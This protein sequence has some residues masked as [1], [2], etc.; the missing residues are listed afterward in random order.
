MDLLS[1]LRASPLICS[2]SWPDLR[3]CRVE[4]RSSQV[5]DSHAMKITDWLDVVASISRPA[6]RAGCGLKMRATNQWALLPFGTLRSNQDD[7]LRNARL[8]KNAH[9]QKLRYWPGKA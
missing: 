3:V 8:S 1:V 9:I 6:E 7:S 5:C 2:K 4:S